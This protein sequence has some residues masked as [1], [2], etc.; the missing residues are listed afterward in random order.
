MAE[1][2]QRFDTFNQWVS[3]ASSWLTR[4]PAFHQERFRAICFDSKGR[5]CRNGGDMMRARDEDAFPVRWVWP[6]QIGEIVLR[7][8]RRIHESLPTL[9]TPGG[10]DGR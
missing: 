5:L 1:H 9:P 8:E 2:N 7:D 3:K 10:S 6:D 4:H